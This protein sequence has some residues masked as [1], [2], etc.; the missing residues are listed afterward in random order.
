MPR[1]IDADELQR[2]IDAREDFLLVDLMPP[3]QYLLIHLPGAINIP[4]DYLHEVLAY[5]PQDKDIILYCTNEQCE[6]S[7][8]GA[9][10][11]ELH[12][13][14]N[15]V[16]LKGGLAEWEKTGRPFATILLRPVDEAPEP[17]PEP[18]P[19]PEPEL[20]PVI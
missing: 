2:R 13:F 1:Q 3:S 8:V 12:G 15:V 14:T 6:F 19:E 16:I 9:R 4:L 10:K 5:L 18:E 20:A 17:Q 7:E 11:L